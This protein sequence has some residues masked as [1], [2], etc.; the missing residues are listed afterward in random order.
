[1]LADT[2]KF[3]NSK[4]KREFDTEERDVAELADPA[5]LPQTVSIRNPHFDITPLEL[6]TG[7]VT[8]RG[9]MTPAAVIT[10]LNS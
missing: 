6:L 3:D 1:V 10:F 5:G 2:L 4:G 8:E 7:V 9:M